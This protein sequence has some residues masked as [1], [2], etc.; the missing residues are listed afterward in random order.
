MHG[1]VF[2]LK[3]KLDGGWMRRV[4]VQES[5][6]LPARCETNV[7]VYTVHRDF[8]S[9][10]ETWA[11]RPGSPAGE[12]RVARALVPNRGTDVSLRVMILASYPVTLTSGTALTELE[13]VKAVDDIGVESEAPQRRYY[14]AHRS[15]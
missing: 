12:V 9:T 15:Q 10:W 11:S 14:R 8:T 6:H 13:L 4:V 3:P 5:V 1:K 7:A 2:P